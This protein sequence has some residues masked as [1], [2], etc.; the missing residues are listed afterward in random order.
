MDLY[1]RFTKVNFFYFQELFEL[2]TR[3]GSN[4]EFVFLEP[5]NFEFKPAMRHF[6]KDEMRAKYV[7][8]LTVAGQ[9]FI[10]ESDMPQSA[11]H[12]AAAAAIPVLNSM[13]D[14]KPSSSSSSF[15][16]GNT[17]PSLGT[18]PNGIKNLT[19]KSDC[20]V[21]FYSSSKT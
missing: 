19:N 8:Q 16:A 12:N 15:T 17:D 1:S 7:V 18:L 9:K 11:K 6:T 3:K 4:P 13:S 14:V 5:P 2:A 21:I 20:I 10:G